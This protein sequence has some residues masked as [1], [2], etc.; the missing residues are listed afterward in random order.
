MGRVATFNGVTEVISRFPRAALFLPFTLQL[1][2]R[3]S[4]TFA[5]YGHGCARFFESHRWIKR[6]KNVNEKCKVP[7]HFLYASFFLDFLYSIDKFIDWRE[8]LRCGKELIW[9]I[10]INNFFFYNN[11]FSTIFS[12]SFFVVINNL[13]F[14][15]FFSNYKL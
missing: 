14:L 13:Q 6:C 9:T 10:S 2:F 12:F 11:L 5:L 4:P 15:F 1:S 3:S 7:S 8:K